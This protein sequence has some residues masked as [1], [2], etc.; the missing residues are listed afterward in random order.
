MANYL[1]DNNKALN[2]RRINKLLEEFRSDKSSEAVKLLSESLRNIRNG[3]EEPKIKP[4]ALYLDIIEMIREQTALG[5]DLVE[6][7]RNAEIL[8]DDLFLLGENTPEF[9]QTAEIFKLL[10]GKEGLMMKG[11]YD[12]FLLVSFSDKRY[13]LSLV[14]VIAQQKQAFKLFDAICKNALEVREF[15]ADDT[16]YLTY[17]LKLV[18]KMSKV[19]P[20]SYKVI[21]EEEL[22][23]LRRSNGIYDIDP[24]RLAQVEKNVSTAALTVESGKNTLQAIEHKGREM[25]RLTRELDEK[26][27]ETVRSM[28]AYLDEKIRTAKDTMNEILKDYENTQKKSIYLEKDIFLKQVFSDAEAQINKYKAVA[29][30]ITATAAA[31]VEHLSREADEVIKR[32]KNAEANH[33][34]L[35]EFSDRSKQ[36]EELLKKIENL[37]LINDSMMERMKAVE[38]MQRPQAGPEGMMQPPMGPGGMAQPPM[39]HEGMMQRPPMGPEGMMQR[40]PMGPGGMAQRPPM[41]PEGMI[42]HE[43]RNKRGGPIP[44]VNPLLD[45]QVPFKDR[46]AVVMKEKK[47]RMAAGE[48]FHKMFDDVITAVMEE[49]NPYLIGPSG[50]GK[51]YMVKQIGEILNVELSDIGYINEEYDILG[52]VTAMG[53]YSESNFYWLYKYGGIAFC[54]ELDNGNGKATVKLNSFLSNQ[55]HANYCFPGGERVDKHPNFR[56]IA[57]GNTDGTGADANYNTRER[58][59]ES[60]LQRMIPIYVDYDNRVEKEILRKYPNWYE[61]CCAFREATD[62]WEEVCGIPA[63]GIFTTRDAFRIKQYLDNGSFTPEKIM[64]Y[65]FVQTKEPEYLGFLKEEIGKKIEK[66]SQAYGIYQIFAD[67]VDHIRRKGRKA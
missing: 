40:P 33:E 5:S 42:P 6:L 19:G 36:D 61:F 37:T 12:P 22:I 24:V 7:T 54:D 57:A 64:N 67:E 47:R 9:E 65:E 34:R 23:R 11:F 4:L 14:Q 1:T 18:S 15:L 60:V 28:D 48:L 27:K 49:V 31:D 51:T 30:T 39:G 17:L 13:Y 46:F 59:E 16:L 20:D 58:I 35:K 38:M 43:P 44:A 45:R 66:S 32:L 50:C 26:T 25:E 41:M 52:Y 55:E 63:Q 2:I 56:V 10:A 53:E 62:H 3:K 29:G 8:Y 21:I